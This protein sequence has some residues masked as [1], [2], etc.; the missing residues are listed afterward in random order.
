[1]NLNLKAYTRK[2]TV[3]TPYTYSVTHKK[4]GIHYYGS[5][6]SKGCSPDDFFKTYFTSCKIIHDL[7]KR[8]GVEGFEFKIRKTFKDTLSCIQHE[9]KFLK[10]VD[11]KN[12]PK[13][14]N[15]QNETILTN[16]GFII[17]TNETITIRWP[18]EKQIPEG[19]KKGNNRKH[20]SVT[21]GRMWIH[22]PITKETRMIKR[23]E[24]MPEG[25]LPNR[26]PEYFKEHSKK[27]K[28]R[29]LIYITNGSENRYISKTDEIP[30]GWR[31]GRFF[32]NPENLGKRS[33]KY[34]T[35]T[36]GKRN[37]HL[38]IGEPIPE[39]WRRGKTFSEKGRKASSE[40][41][42]KYNDSKSV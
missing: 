27:L 21:K 8:E 34:I 39:G 9:N 28:D 13:F 15:R 11:A 5:R 31:K 32:R 19:F 22:N 42:R 29:N 1:M 41:I 33:Y 18:M 38:K 16:T 2:K 17:I 3:S 40:T 10:R 30:E 24:P 23:D 36:D 26:P 7:I 35:I 6:Y 37:T 4:T 20:C 14:F 25:F 12:N